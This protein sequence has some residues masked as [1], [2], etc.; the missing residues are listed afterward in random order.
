M[1]YLGGA[2]CLG[3]FCALFG[4][5]LNSSLTM[6]HAGALP[7]CVCCADAVRAVQSPAGRQSLPRTPGSAG[8]QPPALPEQLS[9]Q[10]IEQQMQ[11]RVSL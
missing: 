11:V 10:A 9:S 1:P 8:K 5:V 6:H 3:P 7:R 4:A 2:A